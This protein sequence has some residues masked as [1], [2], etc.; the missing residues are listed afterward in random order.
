MW[1]IP[2]SIYITFWFV[3]ISFWLHLLK[4]QN[5]LKHDWKHPNHQDQYPKEGNFSC[6]P[7]SYPGS[8]SAVRSVGTRAALGVRCI[9]LMNSWQLRIAAW[10]GWYR[11]CL[12]ILLVS[13]IWDIATGIFNIQIG[14]NMYKSYSETSQNIFEA[15]KTCVFWEKFTFHQFLLYCVCFTFVNQQITVAYSCTLSVLW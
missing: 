4:V 1:Q 15:Q 6:V 7:C 11:W 14:E 2:I 8:W 10:C 5:W 3:F 13:H 12:V 9:K